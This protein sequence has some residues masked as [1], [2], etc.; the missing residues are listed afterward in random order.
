MTIYI[1]LVSAKM[2]R[3]AEES[4]ISNDKHQIS[5]PSPVSVQCIV[6]VRCW[7]DA[8]YVLPIQVPSI[9]AGVDSIIP[10][11]IQMIMISDITDHAAAIFL[12]CGANDIA[13]PFHNI[14]FLQ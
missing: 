13:L 1:Q 2:G 7:R 8:Y 6:L 5:P 14:Q 11:D 9:E 12:V 3:D 4:I 10:D